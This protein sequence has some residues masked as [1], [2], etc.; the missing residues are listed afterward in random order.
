MKYQIFSEK[1]T[2][3]YAPLGVA[4]VFIQFHHTV[5]LLQRSPRSSAPL[6]WTLPGGKLEPGETPLQAIA[7]EIEE[8]LALRPSPEE[9]LFLHS[10]YV[11]KPDLDYIIHLFEWRL[12]EKKEVSL[13]SREHVA[14]SWV[15]R[16]QVSDF[17]L[18]DGGAELFRWFYQQ[19]RME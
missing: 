18:L 7:R 10:F 4:T 19:Q 15:E 14:Y 2:D 16:G 5:L 13:N 8:E 11:R 1:P 12:K 3:F 9:L 17:P 6:L